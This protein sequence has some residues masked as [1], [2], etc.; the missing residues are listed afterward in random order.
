MPNQEFPVLVIL[1]GDYPIKNW[2]LDRPQM[3]VGRDDTCDIMIPQRQISRQHI[4]IHQS[5]DGVLIEDL[6]S[7]NGTWVNGLRL[8]GSRPLSDGD[9]IHLALTVRL[10]YV[11]SGSTAPVTQD[12]PDVLNI[13]QHT[14]HLRLDP[15]GRRVF[16]GGV[17]LNPPL[18][19]PQYRML[20]LLYT[21]KGRVCT[22]EEVVAYVWPDV[23]GEGVSEQAID[24]LVRRLRDRLAELYSETN[25]IITVR[26]HGFRLEN[27]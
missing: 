3:V 17:E 15:D 13:P 2:L 8:E 11:A 9:E 24:A 25:F 4:I 7:R 1:E 5:P 26:G 6:N 18:S 19:V 21:Q 14:G 22:R 23:V 10:R 12:L 20:E 16:V 27:A